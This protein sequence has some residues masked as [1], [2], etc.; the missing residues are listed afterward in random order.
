MTPSLSL[1]SAGILSVHYHTGVLKGTFNDRCMSYTLVTY[2]IFQYNLLGTCTGFYLTLT[3]GV[4]DEKWVQL[5][6]FSFISLLF[7]PRTAVFSSSLL[8]PL[9]N[10]QLFAVLLEACFFHYK[11][12]VVFLTE[13]HPATQWHTSRKKKYPRSLHVS[14]QLSG[15]HCC[16]RGLPIALYTFS[17][18]PL[19]CNWERS[20][21][22]K[23]FLPPS[24]CIFFTK[25][26]NLINIWITFGQDKNLSCQLSTRALLAPETIAVRE[27]NIDLLE[28]TF[29]SV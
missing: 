24:I 16:S 27:I 19:I 25:L 15:T 17:I 22:K 4:Q 8:R 2:V 7:L 11:A 28:N 5:H 26:S 12:C 1:T 10:S 20:M 29:H 13:M 3:L 9:R 18:V 21:E 23:I 6:A 14:H